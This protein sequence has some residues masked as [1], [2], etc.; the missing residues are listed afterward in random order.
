MSHRDLQIPTNVKC[1]N[2]REANQQNCES[3]ALAVILMVGGCSSGQ[4]LA[5][6]QES[7]LLRLVGSRRSV[8][9][10]DPAELTQA[11]CSPNIASV[12]S[13]LGDTCPGGTSQPRFCRILLTQQISCLLVCG[14]K[15]VYWTGGCWAWCKTFD[16]NL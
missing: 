15:R 14:T 3:H 9:K 4:Y 13:S 6:P 16:I 8:P 11:D 5:Q 12:P 1:G 7:I 2:T 10:A